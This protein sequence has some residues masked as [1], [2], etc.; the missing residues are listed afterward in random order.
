MNWSS[1]IRRI[2]RGMSILFTL[3]TTA[4][5]I[6]SGVGKQPVEWVYFLPLVPLFVLLCTGLYM[7]VLPYAA[8]RSGGP[9]KARK[10]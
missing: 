6:T 10:G 1:W 7:F 4:I 3:V 8:K 2:H 5:L 9:A